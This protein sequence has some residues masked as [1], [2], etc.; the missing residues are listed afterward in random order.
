YANP[1]YPNNGFRLQT[2]GR[3]STIALP[4]RIEAHRE[5]RPGAKS[6]NIAPYARGTKV[7]GKKEELANIREP[8]RF[9]R[10][11]PNRH[12]KWSISGGQSAKQRFTYDF[13]IYRSSRVRALIPRNLQGPKDNSTGPTG[14]EHEALESLRFQRRITGDY[15][16]LHDVHRYFGGVRRRFGL[17]ASTKGLVL[18]KII[19]QPISN[20]GAHKQELC[21]I[22][23]LRQEDGSRLSLQCESETKNSCFRAGQ[24]ITYSRF[25]L[26]QVIFTS[27]TYDSYNPSTC[28]ARI[29]NLPR[30]I[31]LNKPQAL[32]YPL[33]PCLTRG[34]R[35]SSRFKHG[36]GLKRT[37]KGDFRAIICSRQAQRTCHRQA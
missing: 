4:E 26:I 23:V 29:L 1:C 7:I 2:Q 3:R 21:A 37:R 9:R 20:H 8:P 10:V 25:Q 18:Q 22:G 16:F 11:Y 28:K 35:L 36:Q 13:N 19:P 17:H 24:Q 12:Q 31:D 15:E 6:K 33:D 5:C 34:N 27:Q 14:S 32:E 30:S